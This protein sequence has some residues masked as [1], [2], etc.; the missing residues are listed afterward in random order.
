MRRETKRKAIIRLQVETLKESL[1]EVTV[2]NATLLKELRR[3]DFM[4]YGRAGRWQPAPTQLKPTFL[5]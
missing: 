4:V 1:M 3:L 5:T 2:Q